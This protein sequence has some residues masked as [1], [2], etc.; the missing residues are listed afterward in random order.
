MSMGAS[1]GLASCC[2][3]GLLNLVD[4]VHPIFWKAN[5]YD[6]LNQ[7]HEVR[8]I[9]LDHLVKLRPLLFLYLSPINI[10]AEP[11]KL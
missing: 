6:P 1:R 5:P 4:G 9:D 10:V 8:S 7:E 3:L 11:P 2:R